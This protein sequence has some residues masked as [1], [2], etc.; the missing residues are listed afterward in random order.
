MNLLGVAL[1]DEND[2]ED[3]ID[4]QHEENMLELRCLKRIDQTVVSFFPEVTCSFSNA[5]ELSDEKKLTD[6]N[7]QG[8]L[9]L[10]KC[11]KDVYKMIL[12]NKKNLSS[13]VE[14]LYP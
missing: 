2:F 13:L 1:E 10:V 7:M 12:L 4:V 11:Q 8:P 14:T 5:Y 9:Y 3:E 6:M